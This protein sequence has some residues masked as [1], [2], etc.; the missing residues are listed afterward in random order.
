MQ[1]K[2]GPCWVTEFRGTGKGLYLCSMKDNFS[3]QADLY[4]RHRPHYPS[5]LF[6]F[7]L[8]HVT[9]HH[10]AWDCATGNGQTAAALAPHFEKVYATDIS[11]QQL[12]RATQLP[13]IVY[14][15]QPAEKTDFPDNSFDLVT[16]SQALHWLRFEEFY[17]ELKRVAKDGSIFAAWT[18]SL[19]SIRPDIDK[20]LDEF[21][22][23]KLKGYWDKE[24]RYV[25]EQYL[26]VPF[27]FE[28][29]ISPRFFIN[30]EWSIR[31]LEGYIGSWSA[32][33]KFIKANNYDPVKELMKPLQVIWGEEIRRV[34]FPLYMRIGRIKK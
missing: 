2:V 5:S 21:Y 15:R 30:L 3:S 27:P 29:I 16:V 8:S 10:A 4:A 6:E 13:N 11:Q 12:E 28:E 14:S 18:Y 31:D 22:K 23:I 19:L 26:T 24:R 17:S 20:H 1:L 9:H 33:Q 34:N 7:I 25:D 32:V